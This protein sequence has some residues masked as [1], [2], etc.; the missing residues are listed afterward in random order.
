MVKKDKEKVSKRTPE[1]KAAAQAAKAAKKAA[2][3]EKMA[4][5]KAAAKEKMAARK[6]QLSSK[7]EKTTG[8][9]GKSKPAGSK[10]KT[11]NKFDVGLP[12]RIQ[13]IIGFLIPVLFCVAIGAISYTKASEGL[14]TNYEGSSVTALEMTMKSMDEA[15]NTIA[16]IAME[17]AQDKTVTAYSLGGYSSDTGKEAEARTT[18]RNNL[19]VKQ[20][21]SEMIEAIHIIP[22][23]DGVVV[24]THN[25]KSTTEL[26]SFIDGLAAS[27]ESFLLDDMW[28]HWYSEHSYIDSQ[29]NTGNYIMYCSRMFKSGGLKGLVVIDV[30]KEAVAKL[31]AQLDF[32]E[33]S[34]VSFIT[35][36]GAEISTD[37]NFSVNSVEGIDWEKT[38]DYIRYNGKTYFYMTVQ[39]SVTG[40]RLLA[41]VPKSYITQSSDSIRNI[42]MGMVIL[43]CLV[44][45]GLSAI[46]IT[47]IGSNITKS[48]ARLDRVSKG[49]LTASDKKEKLPQNEFGKLHGAL[50][51]TVVKMRGLIGT[52]SDMKDAV[53]VSGDNVMESG[54]ELSTMTENVSAQIEEIDS[55]IARQNEAITDC[56]NQM[57]ELSVQIK[58]V[59]NSIFSTIDEVTDS[60]K[61]IDEGMAT[62]EEMVNQSG[63]T[64]D[65]TK[66]VQEHV[67][68]LA[69]KLGQIADFVNNIQEI[70]SQTNLLSLNA[71]IEAARAGEQGRGFSVVA[72]EIRKL[73]DNSGQTA[74]E[75]NKIIEE[76]TKYSQNALKKVGEAE[77]I[78]ANQ[79]ESA[80]KTI[81]AFDQM[82]SLMEGL[83]S[84]MKGI[85]KD[86]D[87]MNQ[88]R[89]SALEAIRG[90]GESS[91]HTVKA[92][93]EVN[94]FLERQ[95]QAAES[96]QT[97]TAKMKED[98][99][100]LEEAIQTFKL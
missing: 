50:S 99:K 19:N 52:V 82:N 64:A 54:T 98:M 14:V 90:I 9:K 60:Q 63:Q 29:M 96:L 56:N 3:K 69:D 97:E 75:I 34:Y 67:V 95:T 83:V 35:A 2:A 20:T 41:L 89:H 10:E 11:G 38:S 47:V 80:K 26:D 77:N 8:G 79:M 68:K 30:G 4:A 18:I 78:S 13:L 46:I 24:T 32:G 53:L 88:R 84:S 21:A 65:A 31:L 15:M 70:A 7:K 37:E 73:A 5:R 85:S 28:V 16:S 39:S 61:M 17:L 49:D 57:E 42:T 58:G 43:A 91:E 1:E 25:L 93:D 62:V 45:V 22:V 51:N 59:S 94:H 36:D 87:E 66:E 55:I 76:I 44:A 81:T 48:V 6:V 100:Q 74:T 23:K 71:S 27:D 86:V 33:G 92:T 72:E 40:G 12:I